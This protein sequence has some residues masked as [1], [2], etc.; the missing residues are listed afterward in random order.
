MTTIPENALHP[1]L[2]VLPAA[3][4]SLVA[5]GAIDRAKATKKLLAVLHDAVAGAAGPLHQIRTISVMGS[6]ARG[7][8][9]VGDIDLVIEVEDPRDE[10]QARLNDYFDM[11]R[12]K[13]P[14]TELLRQLRCSGT[15]MVNAIVVRRYGPC[16]P[17][18]APERWDAQSDPD[19]ELAKPP[20]LGHIVTKEPLAGPAILLYVRGDSFETVR[21]RQADI[22]EDPTASRFGR[23]TGVPLLDDL[24]DHL[25]VE[26]QYKLADLVLAGGLH[27]DAVE[28]HASENVATCVH[29]FE[30]SRHSAIPG[31]KARRSAVLAAIDHLLAQGVPARRLALQHVPLTRSSAH[32]DVS[33]AWGWATLYS[34]ADELCFRGQTRVLAIL[35]SRRRGPWIALDC[36]SHDLA[37]LEE[38]DRAR[39]LR[40]FR[41]E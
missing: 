9:R 14:D 18:V 32:P 3:A 20:Q 27:L 24:A 28:L 30:R 16:P 12:G 1:E 41:P 31:G 34:I 40:A 17:P 15:S 29:R 2:P 8:S 11:I 5:R 33:I 25:G 23:T 7:A 39:T 22:D 38:T 37:M 4:R 19:H 13:N 26:V 10:R 36:R 21:S 6:Y 35:Q